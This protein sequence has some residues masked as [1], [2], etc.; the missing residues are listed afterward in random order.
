MSPEA[1]TRLLRV[2]QDGEYTRV[3]GTDLIS[4]NAR[5]IA[6]TNKDLSNLISQGKFR[7]DL[8]FRLNVV[9]LR[10]PPLR[11]RTED[12]QLL[13]THFLQV[14]A[15]NGLPQKQISDGALEILEN[16]SW[17]GNIRELENFVK[18]SS[19][20]IDEEIISKKHTLNLLSNSEEI[21]EYEPS[22][23]TNF[24]SLIS[25]FIDKYFSDH[26]IGF[27][28]DNLYV[29]VIDEVER[30]LIEKTLENTNGNQIKAAEILGL[31]RNTLR[32]K[33]KKHE[34][35]ISSSRKRK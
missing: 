33:I 17:P 2:L 5:I 6:A 1:Q 31:N 4:S 21:K 3:G 32:K 27:N 30:P 16:H 11:N 14:S 28:P 23:N 25:Y 24:S 7:E 8:Y 26:S 10:L 18:R 35:L 20:L 12:I 19:V 34:I 9:P 15:L 13:L 22:N 29:K